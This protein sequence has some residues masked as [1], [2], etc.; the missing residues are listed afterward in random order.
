[1]RVRGGT[2]VTV[3]VKTSGDDVKG[4]LGSS[5]TSWHSQWALNTDTRYTVT[6]R[7]SMPPDALWPRPAPSTR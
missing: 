7:L 2:L 3:S 1:V 5:A 4:A 6:P